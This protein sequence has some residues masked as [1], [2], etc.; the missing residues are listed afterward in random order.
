MIPLSELQVDALAETFNIS[1]GEAASTFAQIVGTEVDI[2]VPRV[3][4]VERH[5]I[6]QHLLGAKIGGRVCGVTQRFEAASDFCAD[7]LLI[8]PEEGGLE[9]VRC[10]LGE[11]ASID[12]ITELE[13]DA[14]AEVGN[15][16]I[17]ACM[18]SLAN[19]LGEEMN[20]SLPRVLL[21][22]PDRLFSA[23]DDGRQI[24][25]AHIEMRMARHAVRGFVVFTMDMASVCSFIGR[26][27]R[28]FSIG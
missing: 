26:V 23:N 13:Q 8:F 12:E 28:A 16:I 25:M 22:P 1:I 3:E 15:I 2:S 17:N 5:D 20:G 11:Q 9:V 24:L 4:F 7:T 14:L 19:F 27:E 18:S 10:M 21:C 6:E